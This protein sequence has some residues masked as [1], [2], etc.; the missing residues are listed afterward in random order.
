MEVPREHVHTARMGFQH[1]RAH[2]AARE[3]RREVDKI[4]TALSPRQRIWFSNILR[5]LDEA[6]DSVLNNIAEGN[7]SVYP[8]KKANFFDTARNSC[9]ETRSALQSLVERNAITH[10][11][12][13]R[14]I[15]L[16]YV[17][18]K[19]LYAMRTQN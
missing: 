13:H 17:I 4:L 5:H 2:G 14:A 8:R 11:Q 16:T 19:M 1:L 3:L 9:K 15:G 18:P 6:V 10:K 7:D 12:A